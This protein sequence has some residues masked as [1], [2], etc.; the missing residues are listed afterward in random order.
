MLTVSLNN[1]QLLDIKQLIDQIIN[2]LFTDTVNVL[3]SCVITLHLERN[4]Y[5]SLSIYS[6]QIC[7][8]QGVFH[9]YFERNNTMN[10]S[11]NAFLQF[12]DISM[13]LSCRIPIIINMEM[14]LLRN[15]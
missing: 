15:H 10:I 5:Y 8:P 6:F 12:V 4:N 1:Q 3:F 14:K 2:S 7:F 11:H 9:R 13:T